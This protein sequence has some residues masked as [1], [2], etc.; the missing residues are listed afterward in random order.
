VVLVN[1]VVW[2]IE[3][4]SPT[5]VTRIALDDLENGGYRIEVFPEFEGIPLIAAVIVSPT[6]PCSTM[7]LPFEI[8]FS[9][10]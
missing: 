4:T 10:E 5:R 6:A 2:V 1:W 9:Q 8:T 7:E 3:L